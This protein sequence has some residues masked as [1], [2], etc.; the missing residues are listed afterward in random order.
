MCGIVALIQ[1]NGVDEDLLTRLT[2]GLS[3]RGPDGQGIKMFDRNRVAFGHRR[4]V[5]ATVWAGLGERPRP[6]FGVR[7]DG[8]G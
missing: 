8:H 4:R 2:A 5:I 7:G 3:H 6:V 1:R